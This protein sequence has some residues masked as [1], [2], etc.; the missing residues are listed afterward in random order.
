MGM[1]D[2]RHVLMGLGAIPVSGSLGAQPRPAAETALRE[3]AARKGM[4]FGSAVQASQLARDAALARA[5]AQECAMIVPEWEMK[6]GAV[7]KVRG[8]RDFGFADQ[9]ATFAERHGIALRGHVATWYQNLPPWAPEAL[10]TPQG[11]RILAEHVRGILAHFRGRA[12]Q[13]DAV[14]E[15]VAPQNGR[16]DGLRDTVLLRALGPEHIADTFFAA[17]EADASASL[18]YNEAGLEYDNSDHAARRRATLRLLEGLVRRGAPIQGFGLQGHIE[19]AGA[20]LAVADLRSFFRAVAALGL[21]LM[22]T[23]MDVNDRA[24]EGDIAARDI[25]VADAAKAFLE[26]AFAEPAMRGLIVWGMSDR[27]TWLNGKHRWARADGLQNR[28]LPLDAALSRKPLWHVI[29]SA[30]DEAAPRT[31]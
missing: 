11:K 4:I 24:V 16:P 26:I 2:R 13:W 27:Y 1:L 6:W 7:E 5:V 23:E 25:A 14:N 12:V 18:Y 31:R 9:I 3:R 10:A 8:S 17:R 21:E 30:F 29:A 28:C 15:A 20:R 19:A 22:I